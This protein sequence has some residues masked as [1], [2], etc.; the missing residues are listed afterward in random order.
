MEDKYDMSGDRDME[1][2]GLCRALEDELHRP[3]TPEE[4]K[5]ILDHICGLDKEQ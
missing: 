1:Y 2:F 4:K 3:L 5:K